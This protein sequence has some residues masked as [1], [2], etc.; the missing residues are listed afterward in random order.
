MTKET[1]FHLNPVLFL[2]SLLVL[3]PFFGVVHSARISHGPLT[4]AEAHYIRQRQLL[5]YRDEFGDRGELVTVD[6][7]LTFENPRLRNAYI[8]LQA[9]KEAILSDPSN[10]T[11]DWVGSDVCKYTGVFCSPAPD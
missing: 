7:T 3:L 11:G 1:L 2:L 8:A 10:F 9:W 6:P 4:D 5:S